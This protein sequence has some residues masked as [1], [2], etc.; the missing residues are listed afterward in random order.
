MTVTFK[1]IILAK[2]FLS[3]IFTSTYAIIYIWPLLKHV[4]LNSV[5]NWCV[6]FSFF[7][8]TYMYHVNWRFI[9]LLTYIVSLMHTFLLY[10]YMWVCIMNILNGIL[11]NEYVRK[12]KQFN[13][14]DNLNERNNSTVLFFFPVAE[15]VCCL[16]W[17]CAEVFLW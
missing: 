16:V 5:F 7:F 14:Y 6:I 17:A 8:S 12:A 1:K 4:Q 9:V 3:N 2:W 10:L 15:G 11:N 13:H